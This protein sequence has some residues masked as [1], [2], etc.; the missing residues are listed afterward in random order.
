MKGAID[1]VSLLL[2]AHFEVYLSKHRQHSNLGRCDGDHRINV[3]LLEMPMIPQFSH[4]E[5]EETI[6]YTLEAAES[7]KSQFCAMPMLRCKAE[8]NPKPTYIA[9]LFLCFFFDSSK[10]KRP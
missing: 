4:E 2:S 8:G 1:I 9:T 7:L 3:I 6:Y 5:N 10:T